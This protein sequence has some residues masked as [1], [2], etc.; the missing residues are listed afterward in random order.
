MYKNKSIAKNLET[1][2]ERQDARK[3]RQHKKE[4][5]QQHTQSK[6]WKTHP[7]STRQRRD[8]AGTQR[9][10]APTTDCVTE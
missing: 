5:T 7:G 9:S 1:R 4:E 8:E 3:Q 2:K 6:A 10:A